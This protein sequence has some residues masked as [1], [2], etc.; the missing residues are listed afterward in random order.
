LNAAGL[1]GLNECQVTGRDRVFAAFDGLAGYPMPVA[2]AYP[3]SL[4]GD[5][6]R[7]CYLGYCLERMGPRSE[8]RLSHATELE[9]WICA[10]RDAYRLLPDRP[11]WTTVATHEPRSVTDGSRL[12]CRDGK[13]YR[14]FGDG[15]QRALWENTY[16]QDLWG[17]KPLRSRLDVK[18]RIPVV[19]AEQ[20][21]EDGRFELPR[22]RISELEQGRFTMTYL[23]PPFATLYDIVG[24]SSM[25]TMPLDS[26]NLTQT[27]LERLYLRDVEWARACAVV[28]FD[29]ILLEN[30]LVSADLIS[31]HLFE[32]FVLPWDRRF[33]SALKEL[34]LRVVHYFCGDVIPRLPLL[35]E[36]EVDC[37]AVEE[38]KK[39]FDVDIR[40]VIVAVGEKMCVAGNVDAVQVPRWSETELDAAIERQV[41]ASHGALGFVIS[42]GSPF[43]SDAPLKTL[44][45]FME[46]G[47]RHSGKRYE[48]RGSSQRTVPTVG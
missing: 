6:V 39:G 8:V 46:T 40:Q 36:M 33:V 3:N 26:P 35:G 25:M 45:D 31:P 43:P 18:E 29:G 12:V 28:G 47:R 44:V 41:A 17:N 30:C 37:L 32:R 9:M 48:N 11:D 14:V 38:S 1:M 23:S 24:F 15:S 19:S 5:Q 7:Q 27:L 4:L 16:A 42:T 2:P 22:R 20:L 21:L 34:G 10:W 13:W